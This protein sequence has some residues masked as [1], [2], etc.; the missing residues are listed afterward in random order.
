MPNSLKEFMPKSMVFSQSLS[1]IP[2]GGDI[3][4]QKLNIMRW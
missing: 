3:I 1:L 2:A 4:W